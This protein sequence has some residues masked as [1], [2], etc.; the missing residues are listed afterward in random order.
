MKLKR[1]ILVILLVLM[2]SV[3]V[4][5]TDDIMVET[6]V[7]TTANPVVETEKNN[8]EDVIDAELYTLVDENALYQHKSIASELEDAVYDD[9]LYLMD[10]TVN[11]NNKIITGNAF[12]MAQDIDLKDITIQGSLYLLGVNVNLDS[13]KIVGSIYSVAEQIDGTNLDTSNIYTVNKSINLDSKSIINKSVYGVAQNMLIDSVINKNFNVIGEIIDFGNNVKILGDCNI[14]AT[15]NPEIA[16]EAI[17]GEYNFKLVDTK[18]DEKE[19][20]NEKIK[21]SI[22]SGITSLLFSIIVLLVI[23]KKMPT[24]KEK[25]QVDNFNQILEYAVKGFVANIGLPILLGVLLVAG[26]FTGVGLKLGITI[27]AMYILMMAVSSIVAVMSI[28]ELICNK[29]NITD[30]KIKIAIFVGAAIA[31]IVIE[32]ILG[33]FAAVNGVLAFLGVGIIMFKKK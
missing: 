20:K 27:F 22:K 3:S 4:F 18:K 29:K 6:T 30:E 2:S 31:L 8:S 33:I 19:V 17:K 12:I 14:E 32:Q 21:S 28:V 24:L 11:L 7:D 15:A 10:E 23:Y 9:D 26:I 16:R 5:A 1:I 25:I 13:C